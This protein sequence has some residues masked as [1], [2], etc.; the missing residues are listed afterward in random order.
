MRGGTLKK[1]DCEEWKNEKTF[2][3][4]VWDYCPFCGDELEDPEEGSPAVFCKIC[5][6]PQ[7]EVLYKCSWCGYEEKPLTLLELAKRS[8]P[9][10]IE[11]MRVELSKPNELLSVVEWPGDVSTVKPNGEWE[12]V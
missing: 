12:E 10:S 6:S 7:L 8:T 3:S 11:D 5:G 1:C 4:A 9:K 2:L